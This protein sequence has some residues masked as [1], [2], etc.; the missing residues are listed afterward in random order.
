MKPFQPSPEQAA[1]IGAPPGP[2]VVVAGAGTGKTETL[3]GRLL[4]VLL[5]GTTRA[6]GEIEPP[7]GWHQVVALTFTDKAAAEMRGRIY[8]GLVRRLREERKPERRAR[9]ARWGGG[10][11]GGTGRG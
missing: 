5:E 7:C 4:Q 1:I 2:L 6:G 10:G 8:A 3:T 11:G 9:L